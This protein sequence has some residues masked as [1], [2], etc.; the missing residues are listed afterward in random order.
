[1]MKTSLKQKLINR[2]LT[3]GSWVTIGHPAIAE[4]LASAGFDW[5]VIDIEHTTID[6][7]MVQALI[8]TIQSKGIAA[9]VRVSD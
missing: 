3:I 4:I 5:L 9:I 7:S 2:E 6:L 1:M 8:T